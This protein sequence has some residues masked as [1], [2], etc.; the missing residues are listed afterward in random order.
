[1]RPG[2]IHGKHYFFVTSDVFNQMIEHGEFLEHAI[3]FG[4]AKGT[5]SQQVMHSLQKGLDVVLEIDWQGAQQVRQL[6][7]NVVSIFILP[8]SYDALE[9]RLS[10]RGQDSQEIIALRMEKAHN[11]ISH[12]HEFDYV[13]FNDNFETCLSQIQSIVLAERLRYKEQSWR[14]AERLAHLR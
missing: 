11:E 9:E 2:E 3:V 13:V 7:D 10:Q 14:N 12:C 1:M 4:D 6:F 8:P 5:T